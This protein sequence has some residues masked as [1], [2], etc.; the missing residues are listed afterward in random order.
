M[1]ASIGLVAHQVWW[2]RQ[3]V[4]DVLTRDKR[5]CFYYCYLFHNLPSSSTAVGGNIRTLPEMDDS[6]RPGQ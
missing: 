5:L 2:G 4:G 1:I 6:G 3:H